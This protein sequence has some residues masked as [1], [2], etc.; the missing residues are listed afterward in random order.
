MHH[1]NPDLIPLLKDDRCFSSREYERLFGEIFLNAMV[2]YADDF[3]KVKKKL[4]A[5]ADPEI[6]DTQLAD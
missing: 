6:R 3:E 4:V 5:V 2:K 1:V